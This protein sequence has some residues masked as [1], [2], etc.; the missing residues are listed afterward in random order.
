MKAEKNQVGFFLIKIFV[1]GIV[2]AVQW[3]R[4]LAALTEEW[5][6]SLSTRFGWVAHKHM[7][8]S[9]REPNVLAWSLWAPSFLC[10]LTHIKYKTL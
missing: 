1:T 4:E 9:F 2:E 7:Y 5:S 6:L 8:L 3:L 10:K